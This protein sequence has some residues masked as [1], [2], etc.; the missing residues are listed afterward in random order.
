[1][2]EEVTYTVEMTPYIKIKS[3]E[4]LNALTEWVDDVRGYANDIFVNAK[5]LKALDGQVMHV[6]NH[7]SNYIKCYN[8][9]DQFCEVVTIPHSF[10]DQYIHTL[11]E[12]GE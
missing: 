8:V 9:D 2:N 4:E 6:V 10:V 5:M 3:L 1:M 11:Y 7:G 12:G